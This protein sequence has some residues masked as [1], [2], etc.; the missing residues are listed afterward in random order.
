[1][2]Y[3]KLQARLSYSQASAT[4][5]CCRTLCSEIDTVA[6]VISAPK[7]SFLQS[8][9]PLVEAGNAVSPLSSSLWTPRPLSAATSGEE[10]ETLSYCSCSIYRHSYLTTCS[11]GTS[12]LITLPISGTFRD[13]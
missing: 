1:M 8:G 6:I 9:T 11:L 7:S 13:Q 2:A 12:R 3:Q 5:S 4:G 10:R